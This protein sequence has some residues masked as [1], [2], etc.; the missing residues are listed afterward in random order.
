MKSD[1]TDALNFESLGCYD[2][3]TYAETMQD[4]TFSVTILTDIQYVIT[5]SSP[6]QYPLS[7]I[8]NEAGDALEA[9]SADI[10]D[11]F[12]IQDA[13][14]DVDLCPIKIDPTVISTL[15]ATV[16]VPEVFYFS[17]PTICTGAPVGL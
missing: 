15:T 10:S 11:F 17:T 12:S 13:F 16:G 6:Q 14:Y 1:L 8:L 9:E 5:S 3:T 7:T 4:L 2:L